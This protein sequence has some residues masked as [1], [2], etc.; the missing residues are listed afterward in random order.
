MAAVALAVRLPLMSGPG[1]GPD[2]DEFF[3]WSHRA[4][5]GELADVYRVSLTYRPSNYPPVY[6]YALRGLATVFQ[7]R[8]GRT[9]DDSVRVEVYRGLPTQAARVAV[10]LFKWPAVIA[11]VILGALLVLWLWRRLRPV[12]AVAV[13]CAYVLLPSVIHNS[14]VWGQVDAVPSLFVPIKFPCTRLSFAASIEIPE[15]TFPEMTLPLPGSVPPI[16]LPLTKPP[17]AVKLPT[18]TPP[19]FGIAMVPVMSVPM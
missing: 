12:G 5:V 4:A 14:S 16:L 10:S 6:I 17:T 8:T 19:E 13:S 2:Q 9:L 3:V 7:W 1:F 15:E 11:D 18:L